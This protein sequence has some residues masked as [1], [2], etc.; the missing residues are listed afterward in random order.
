M[1]HLDALCASALARAHVRQTDTAAMVRNRRIFRI[2]LA[3][4]PHER[5]EMLVG[6]RC[7]IRRIRWLPIEL[8]QTAHLN[9][10]RNDRVALT[11]MRRLR[12]SSAQ[13]NQALVQHI[14]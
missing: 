11:R 4:C 1:C 9:D 6:K 3:V 10:I 7:Q 12:R 5:R 14:R 13:Q 2:A 8:V